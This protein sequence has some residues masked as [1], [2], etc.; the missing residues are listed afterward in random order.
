MGWLG[1]A[2][3]IMIG[4]NVVLFGA[5]FVCSEVEDRRKRK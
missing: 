2:A 1:W 5:L 3:L 4:V